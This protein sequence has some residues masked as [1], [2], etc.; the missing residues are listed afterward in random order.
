MLSQ[1][2][3]IAFVILMGVISASIL[4]GT[5]NFT[6]D[7]IKSNEEK[8]LKTKVL[9]AFGIP[10]TSSDVNEVFEKSLT[11]VEKGEVTF[12][13]STDGNVGYRFEGDGVWGP[14]RGFITLAPDHE[15]IKGIRILYQ[16]ETPGL[17][18]I[19]AETWYLDQ[20]KDKKFDPEIII[21]KDADPT[22]ENEVDAITGATNTSIAFENILNNAYQERKGDLKR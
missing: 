21:K 18:G 6:K 1:I 16:E 14:I 20:Y 15:T 8:A 11:A 7:R 3:M 22:V 10:F 2:K 13:Y 5:D 19:V 9:D 4:V 12:F 17:G